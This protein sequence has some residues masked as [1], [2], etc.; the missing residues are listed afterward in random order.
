MLDAATITEEGMEDEH[1][2][3]IDLLE[4]IEK[5]NIEEDL[6]ESIREGKPDIFPPTMDLGTAATKV[7]NSD[8]PIFN[9]EFR[10]SKIALI[11]GTLK[12]NVIPQGDKVV[13]VSQWTSML[14]V[15]EAHL[16]REGIQSEMLSGKVP[17]PKRMMM[18]DAFNS[19]TNKLQVRIDTNQSDQ[20]LAQS[21]TV[22]FGIC[23]RQK[24]RP[25]D[26]FKN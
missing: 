18:V 8:N 21:R 26:F 17:V 7:L 20:N 1:G 3:D 16:L 10:S 9:F 22:Q 25:S 23:V 14:E 15:I 13:I 24:W 11:I 12:Q 5:L 6:N 2:N 19:P 4:Q